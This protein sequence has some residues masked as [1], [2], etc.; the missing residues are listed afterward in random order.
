MGAWSPR[1]GLNRRGILC[2]PKQ[3][4]QGASCRLTGVCTVC[5]TRFVTSPLAPPDDR[6]GYRAPW[7]GVRIPTTA[8]SPL[9]VK[10]SGAASRHQDDSELVWSVKVKGRPAVDSAAAGGG[11]GVRERG[12]VA[13]TMTRNRTETT[14]TKLAEWVASVHGKLAAAGLRKYRQLVYSLLSSLTFNSACSATY[15]NSFRS[16]LPLSHRHP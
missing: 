8:Q 14:L 3:H 7:F 2:V 13:L 10:R 1:F 4:C 16:F 6:T 11:P 15:A 12:P 5:T 9:Q